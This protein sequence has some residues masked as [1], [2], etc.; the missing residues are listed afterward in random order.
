M[1]ESVFFNSFMLLLYL[2]ISLFVKAL[3]P[4]TSCIKAPT[5][6]NKYVAL[7]TILAKYSSQAERFKAKP[8]I[9]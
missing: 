6:F 9:G 7:K 3:S 2:V 8:A 1:S 4:M 5:F